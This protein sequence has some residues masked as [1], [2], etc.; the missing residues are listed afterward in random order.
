MNRNIIRCSLCRDILH[1]DN[2][3]PRADVCD[4]CYELEAAAHETD[5][6]RGDITLEDDDENTLDR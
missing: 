5:M 2:S 3:S 1:D 6:R 4:R